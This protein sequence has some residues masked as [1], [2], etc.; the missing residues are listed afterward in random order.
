MEALVIFSDPYNSFGVSQRESIPPSGN[1][2]EVYGSHVLQCK[3]KNKAKYYI[4]SECSC[5]VIQDSGGLGSP[6]CL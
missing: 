1:I 3:N 2:M 5:G 4:S 6:V